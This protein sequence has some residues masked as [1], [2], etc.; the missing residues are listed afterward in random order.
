MQDSLLVQDKK[1]LI[2]FLKQFP[3]KKTNKTSLPELAPEP[4]LLDTPKPTK[5]RPN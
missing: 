1:Y 4:T 2:T 5:Y 3:T